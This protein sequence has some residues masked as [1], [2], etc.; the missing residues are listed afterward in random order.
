MSLEWQFRVPL[1]GELLRIE[2][3]WDREEIGRTDVSITPDP[4]R[5]LLRA[6][7]DEPKAVELTFAFDDKLLAGAPRVVTLELP[8]P[9]GT[10]STTLLVVVAAGL[11]LVAGGW[12]VV[13]R[14]K[15]ALQ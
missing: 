15:A 3:S 6:G 14:R 2:D 11:V 4:K 8:P 5:P 13:Q 10:S 12:W 1:D 9:S 7:P